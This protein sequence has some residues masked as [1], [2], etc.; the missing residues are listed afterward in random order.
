[1]PNA[2]RQQAMSGAPAMARAA[3]ALACTVA[4]AV[5]LVGCA[6]M[7][8]PGAAP[9]AVS[10]A[11]GHEPAFM[12]HV[13]ADN[14]YELELS[15]LAASRATNPRVRSL[16]QRLAVHRTQS[17]QQLAALMRTRGVPMAAG[18]APEQAGKLRRLQALPRSADFDAAYVRV[19]G[20]EDGLSTIALL[21]RARQE[22]RDPG[23]AAWIDRMLPVMRSDLQAAQRVAGQLAG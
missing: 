15:H 18:L 11:P 22:T 4:T 21:E 6:P 1:M 23:L 14:L 9:P 17:R 5:V 19:V 7:H 12:S 13:A 3:L 10:A 8:G 16:A 20:I 2:R